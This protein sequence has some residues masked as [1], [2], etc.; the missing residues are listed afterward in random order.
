MFALNV[1]KTVTALLM[2]QSVNWI[3]T[4]VKN[5]LWT[6]IAQMESALRTSNVLNVLK[7]VTAQ[8]QSQSAS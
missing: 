5:V 4:L 6:L 1:L 8:R 2:S 3:Q 7:T